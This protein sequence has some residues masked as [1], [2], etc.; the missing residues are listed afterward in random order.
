MKETRFKHTEI[1]KIPED[2]EVKKLKNIVDIQNGDRSPKYPKGKDFVF[3]GIPFINAGHIQ[4]NSIS[5]DKMDYITPEHYKNLSGAKLE[6]DDIIFCLRGSLGKFAKITFNGGAPAS[7]LCVFKKS[8][9]IE[10]DYLCQLL[11]STITSNQII[12]ENNG[13]SQPNLSALSIGNFLFPIS[14]NEEQKKIANYLLDTDSLISSTEM[15]IKKKQNIKQG[16]MQLLITGKKRLSIYSKKGELHQTEIGKIPEDWDVKTLDEIFNFYPNNTLPRDCLNDSEGEYQNIHYG[17]VLIKFPSILDCQ[18]EEIPY[19]N[20][21]NKINYERYGIKEGDVIIADTAEDET[22]GKVTEIYNLG[23]KKIVSGLH[24]ILCRPKTDDFAPKWLGYFMNY[25]MYHNQLI[26]LM[27]GIKVS[28]VSKSSILSTK[29]A[30]PSKEEQI[31]ITNIL[32][33]MDAEIIA[34]K[35]KLEK[36]KKI[37]T[38]MMQ[39]LLTGK[40]RLINNK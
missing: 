16:T 2:W 37:K 27:T 28:S 1:G 17:D 40:I 26:P 15:L 35:A 6:K 20:Y 12:D 8:K 14:T 34:L 13:S 38:G 4:E 29:V 19:I 9:L 21:G 30:I 18:K 11:K 25:S 36:Y 24:T 32:S 31:A 5:F 3:F 22:C 7:S 33:D 23:N 39:Q 10:I